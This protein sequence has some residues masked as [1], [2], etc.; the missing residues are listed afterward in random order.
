MS[1]RSRVRAPSRAMFFVFFF[2][3]VFGNR[4]LCG[5]EPKVSR[6]MMSKAP[7]TSTVCVYRYVTHTFIKQQLPG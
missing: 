4:L 2:C 3:F 7:V 6:G 1:Q 5:F